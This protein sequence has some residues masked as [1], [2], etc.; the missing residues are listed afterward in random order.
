MS[1][2][3]A[4]SGYAGGLGIAK[5]ET[6]NV[7]VTPPTKFLEIASESF[8]E[9]RNWF[10]AA[11]IHGVRS[12]HKFAS[13]ETTLDPRGGFEI[14]G[15]KGAD[16][17]LLIEFALGNYASGSGYP[18]DVLPT[19]TTVVHKPPKYAV[20]AG[21]KLASLQFES[22]ETDQGLK[23]TA[24]AIAM[25]LAEGD[26]EDF[27][28]PVYAQEIPLV[29]SRAS[30]SVGGE[31]VRARSVQVRIANALDDGVFRNSQ[32]R[33]AI[34][35]QGEREVTGELA[36]DWNAANY[37]AVMERWR[38]GA[39]A[40]LRAEYTNGVYVV[41]FVCPNCRCPSEWGRLAD[42]NVIQLPVKFEAYASA[43]GAQDE[44]YVYVRAA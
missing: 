16:L 17:D 3:E 13:A 14:Q 39:Y 26:A 36:L 37:A 10:N 29:H 24:E 5:E 30:F 22:S 4:H 2:Y 34:P 35:E 20:F 1:E 40:E 32:T 7:A 25:S 18:G 19:F 33:L 41:T 15:L 11:G 44:L 23:A 42:K 27:G 6:P 21:C 38:A 43:P 8:N 31:D 12:R 28:T 9:T